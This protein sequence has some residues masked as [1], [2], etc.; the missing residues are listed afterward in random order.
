M[1]KTA[2][3]ENYYQR[4][5][6]DRQING[7]SVFF[8]DDNEENEEYYSRG[9]TR[10]GDAGDMEEWEIS[11][12][13]LKAVEN[14]SASFEWEEDYNLQ[15]GDKIISASVWGRNRIL[16]WSGQITR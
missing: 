6:S 14:G 4:S 1:A 16:L 12:E 7:G 13:A 2:V 11:P 10:Y 8:V 15:T 5:F 3:L 9:N